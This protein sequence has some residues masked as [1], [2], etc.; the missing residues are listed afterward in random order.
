MDR[1]VVKITAEMISS[2]KNLVSQT[3]VHRTKVSPVDTIGGILGEFIFAQW[4]FGDWRRNEVGT[5]KGKADLL[6][7][8]E[9]KT[10]IYPFK[11]TLN[12]T[13]REDYGAKFKDVYVQN[14][15][16]VKDS[17]K[18]HI[19]PGID[20]IICGFATHDQA[21]S[22]PAKP[23]NMRGGGQT[24]FGVFTTPIRDLRPMSEFRG[25]LADLLTKNGVAIDF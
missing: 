23:M 8:V 2:A 1:P 18:K 12:L 14:I 13:I 4:L 20:V 9:I 17:Y 6:G 19:E 3:Q 24:P 5:N 21:T 25:F 16:D 11:E 15:I 7:L 10:S 22:R